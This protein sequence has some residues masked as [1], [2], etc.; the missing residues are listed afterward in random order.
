MLENF[1]DQNIQMEFV[2]KL[3]FEICILFVF[4]VLKFIQFRILQ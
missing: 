3:D 4:R 1:K 2:R